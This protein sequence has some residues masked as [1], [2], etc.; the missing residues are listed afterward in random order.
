MLL[1][2][3]VNFKFANLLALARQTGKAAE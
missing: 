3:L 1:L 2:K